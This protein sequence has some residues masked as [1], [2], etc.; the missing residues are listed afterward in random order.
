MLRERYGISLSHITSI[1]GSSVIDKT[2]ATTAPLPSIRPSNLTILSDEERPKL[3]Q[4]I[5]RVKADTSMD[6]IELPK[7]FFIASKG[8]KLFLFLIY[9]SLIRME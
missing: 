1:A 7:V 8:N 5:A 9:S 4:A 3:N 2:N 6:L